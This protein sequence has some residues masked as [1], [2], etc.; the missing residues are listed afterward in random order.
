MSVSG[1]HQ[2]AICSNPKHF[3][4]QFCRGNY[5]EDGLGL[6]G[7][8]GREGRH[9]RRRLEVPDVLGREDYGRRIPEPAREEINGQP[10]SSRGA[11]VKKE[12]LPLLTAGL[13]GSLCG[14]DVLEDLRAG[15]GADLG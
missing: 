10:D 2:N 6:A 1:E 4:T 13:A 15:V 8:T 9:H 7:A 5:L 3:I 14:V 12:G 11:G